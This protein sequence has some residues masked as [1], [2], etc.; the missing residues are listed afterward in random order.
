MPIL[1][2][3]LR[4]LLIANNE[5]LLKSICSPS[6][7]T[8]FKKFKT[9]CGNYNPDMLR[10]DGLL[11]NRFIAKIKFSS[12]TASIEGLYSTFNFI[13]TN[14]QWKLCGINNKYENSLDLILLTDEF[15]K[16]KNAFNF[17]YGYHNIKSKN[18]ED[19][20]DSIITVYSFSERK[21]DTAIRNAITDLNPNASFKGG[22][23]ALYSYIETSIDK[24]K[25][26]LKKGEIC[27]SFI[28]EKDGSI[29]GIKVLDGLNDITNQEAI[30][31]VKEMPLWN[32]AKK[33]RE[34]VRSNYYLIIPFN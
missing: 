18:E 32:P 3:A 28:V 14:N 34:I 21:E 6:C 22:A 23:K 30:R 15:E 4:E 33:Y 17:N 24:E 29:S 31:L 19:T 13:E 7:F 25:K 1:D 26:G 10:I 27:I 11:V 8:W 9:L 20:D 16:I 12:D 5:Q 2:S